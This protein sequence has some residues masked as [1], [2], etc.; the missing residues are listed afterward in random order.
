MFVV[1]DDFWVVLKILDFELDTFIV[2]SVFFGSLFVNEVELLFLKG[3]F[4]FNWF[5]NSKYYYGY[6]NLY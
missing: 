4:F 5:I 1:L 2:C 3:Y 6:V